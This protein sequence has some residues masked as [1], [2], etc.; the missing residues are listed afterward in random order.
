MYFGNDVHYYGSEELLCGPTV[1]VAPWTACQHIATSALLCAELP[2]AVEMKLWRAP[3]FE[4]SKYALNYDNFCS[5]RGRPLSPMPP[6]RPCEASWTA[7]SV[8][9]SQGSIPTE[10]DWQVA[11]SAVVKQGF[12]DAEEAPVTEADPTLVEEKG[13]VFDELSSLVKGGE[14]AYL[15]LLQAY[16]RNEKA[17]SASGLQPQ[18]LDMLRVA[19]KLDNI[20]GNQHGVVLPQL[21]SICYLSCEAQKA[22]NM[23][24]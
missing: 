9:V 5:V 19:E 16:L 10:K 11:C 23:C 24:N 2:E 13:W 3:M 4:V 17:D 18:S 22:S 8:G 14:A 12:P 7:G 21:A 1:Q 6:L 15:Q 20:P